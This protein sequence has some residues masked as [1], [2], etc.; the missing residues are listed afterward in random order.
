MKKGWIILIAVVV[1]LLLIIG[2]IV[3]MYNNLVTLEEGVNQSWAQV[4]NQYQR[5]ADLIPN[6]VETVKG[7]AKHESQT[8]EAVIQARSNATGL[9]VTPEVLNDPKAFA[10]FQQAQGEISSALSRLMAVVENYPNLKANENFLALQSQLEG[11]E[12]RITV[13]RQRFNE[14]VQGFNTKIRRFPT[15][16]IAGMFGF[17]KKLYFE[18]QEG[19]ENAPKVTF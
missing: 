9:K 5:R 6:L 11:T 2:K 15:N 3:G 8:L 4:S 13:E 14:A 16:I 7:Y 1:V 18:A 17:D 19:A 12:N 10:K